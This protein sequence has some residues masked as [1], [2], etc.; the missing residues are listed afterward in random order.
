MEGAR[1]VRILFCCATRSV[2]DGEDLPFW[3]RDQRRPAAARRRE[4]SVRNP[5]RSSVNTGD[6]C[7]LQSEG[8][9][10][11]VPFWVVHEDD[12]IR[13]I[14]SDLQEMHFI[15][16]QLL[17]KFFCEIGVEYIKF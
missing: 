7:Q 15:V 10:P 14:C 1:L 16:Y 4:Q 12:Q 11:L 6:G 5:H 17:T 13:W 8:D 2:M 3:T 9:A